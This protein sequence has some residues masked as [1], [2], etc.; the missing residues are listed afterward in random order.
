MR[1]LGLDPGLQVTGW[2]VIDQEGSRLIWVADG[3]IR[4][5]AG[6]SLSE[7]LATLYQ[8][9]AEI[10]AR[11]RPDEAAAEEVFVNVNPVSTLKLGQARGAAIVSAAMSGLM[12]HEYSSTRIKNSVVGTGRAAK[13]QVG[14]MVR[15]LLPGSNPK[16]ADAADAL[17]AAICH[18]HFRGTNASLVRALERG[19]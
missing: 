17:A 2:G 14:A 10:I 16:A 7:R 15:I 12:V 11:Y 13:Q 5:D 19:R 3:V 18:A 8:G 1:F 4:T 9:V 6:H